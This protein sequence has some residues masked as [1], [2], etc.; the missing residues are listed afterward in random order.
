[1]ERL[2]DLTRKLL[3]VTKSEIDEERARRLK[4]GKPRQNA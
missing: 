2:K 4:S 1:M 3:A